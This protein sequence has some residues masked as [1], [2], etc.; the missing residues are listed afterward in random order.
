MQETIS[1]R[2]K[3]SDF[4]NE[5]KNVISSQSNA[6]VD[7]AKDRYETATSEREKIETK[8]AN[9]REELKGVQD[10]R[11]SED[12]LNSGGCVGNA[13]YVATTFVTRAIAPFRSQEEPPT[14]YE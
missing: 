1:L 6:Q 3:V 4:I 5:V 2:T 13:C 9:A 12:K 11:G 10:K 7:K 8:L 14:E